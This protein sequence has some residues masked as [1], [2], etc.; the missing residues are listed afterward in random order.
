MHFETI[1]L[2]DEE[3]MMRL[4]DYLTVMTDLKT[5]DPLPGDLT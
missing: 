1:V 3:L 2:D 5:H 4:D